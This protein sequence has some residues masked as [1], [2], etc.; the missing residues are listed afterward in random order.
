MTV[1]FLALPIASGSSRIVKDRWIKY[2]G[3]YTLNTSM[4]AIAPVDIHR[5][6]PLS[7][8]AS[9]YASE[10]L[11]SFTAT[12]FFPAEKIRLEGIAS[13]DSKCFF[14]Y[15]VFPVLDDIPLFPFLEAAM[16]SAGIGDA[17]SAEELFEALNSFFQ[18]HEFSILGVESVDVFSFRVTSGSHPNYFLR[19]V[20]VDGH[21]RS[22]EMTLNISAYE[23]DK[24][25]FVFESRLLCV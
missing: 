3:N 1:L 25:L 13:N 15:R 11:L 22:S 6:E 2:R 4:S 24:D 23:F 5:S 20:K 9:Y 19:D 21:F 10:L 8:S 12:K 7:R 17:E 14:Y 18:R 16:L